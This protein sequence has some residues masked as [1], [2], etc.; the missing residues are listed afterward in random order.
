MFVLSLTDAK[1]QY[2]LCIKSSM[3]TTKLGMGLLHEIDGNAPAINTSYLGITSTLSSYSD[4]YMRTL[5][6]YS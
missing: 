4:K 2:W 1:E 3:F 6:M 5:H